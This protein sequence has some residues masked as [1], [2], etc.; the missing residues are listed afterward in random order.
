MQAIIIVVGLGVRKM[1]DVKMT[2]QVAVHETATDTKITK[3]KF[4]LKCRS[5]FHN[6][7][8]EQS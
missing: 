7:I 1:K 3:Q 8:Q 2:D 4:S 6:A 5:N